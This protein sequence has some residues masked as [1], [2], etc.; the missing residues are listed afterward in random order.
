MSGPERVYAI[1]DIH[2]QI[3]LLRGA[4]AA[5][6]ADLAARPVAEHAVVHVGDYVDRGPDSAG[7]IAHLLAG[8]QA[9][10]PWV[11]LLGN[12]DRMFFRYLA[13]PGGRDQK[14]RNE[15]WWLHERIGGLDTLRSYGVHAPDGASEKRG[16][17]IHEE[18]RAAVPPLHFAFLAGL[19][20]HWSWRGWFFTHAGVKPGVPLAEQVEDDLIWIRDEFLSSMHDHGAVVVHGH[21]PVEAVED[22]GVRIAIDTGA[23]FGGPLSCI[24]IEG[25]GVRVLGG[26]TLR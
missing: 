13:A 16:V 25:A 17:A 1:G 14:L 20:R 22:H 23:A 8:T 9:G 24:A 6:E 11:N 3:A 15:F 5:I 21:T 7:V 26:P 19:R 2:G 12:H 18:A 4:H 10:R